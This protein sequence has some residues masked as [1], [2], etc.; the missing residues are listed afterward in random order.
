MVYANHIQMRP[1]HGP[2]GIYSHDVLQKE[3]SFLRATLIRSGYS[4]KPSYIHGRQR[5]KCDPVYK[6]TKKT[7][8]IRLAFKEDHILNYARQKHSSA[9][10][11]TFPD[12]DLRILSTACG[13]TLNQLESSRISF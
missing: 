7:V 1:S 13:T 3:E 5:R 6:A 11:R 4:V 8:Y 10:N 12:A 2:N 9:M